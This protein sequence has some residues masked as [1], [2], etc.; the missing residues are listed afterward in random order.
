MEAANAGQ[1]LAL[2]DPNDE[3]LLTLRE[4]AA[5]IQEAEHTLTETQA[6]N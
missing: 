3:A 1:A 4:L 6:S 5:R 2:T